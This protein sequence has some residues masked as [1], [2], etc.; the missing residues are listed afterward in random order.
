MNALHLAAMRGFEEVVQTL[1]DHGLKQE[2]KQG[3]TLQAAA[4]KGHQGTVRLLMEH[5]AD[6]H[7]K[8]K[9]SENI[10]H[11]L[12]K[13]RYNAD[14]IDEFLERGFDIN[15]RNIC[16]ETPLRLAVEN[17]RTSNVK[18]L[19]QRGA[20]V[21]ALCRRHIPALWIA[22][23]SG[24]VKIVEL[25]LEYGASTQLPVDKSNGETLLSLAERQ[26]KQRDYRSYTTV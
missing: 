15:A 13:G 4:E 6:H 24:R 11:F 20:D 12:S 26:K 5:D 17:G 19:L 7:W 25:L 3:L 9:Y 21:D 14:L 8:T 10:L 22:V 23:G 16:E 2:A 18:L 1:I